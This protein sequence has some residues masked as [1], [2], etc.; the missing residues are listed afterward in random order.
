MKT[1]VKKLP[2]CVYEITIE[3]SAAE[4]EKARKAAL[5]SLSKRVQVKGFRKGAP[6]PEAL[7]LKEVGPGAL[8][9]EALDTYLKKNYSKIL[10]SAKV[11]PIAPG[12]VTK[13]TSLDPL[14]VSIEVETLPEV[15]IDTKKMDSITIKKTKVEADP[16]EVDEAVAEIE[17]RFTHFHDAGGHSED[18]FDASKVQID[19]GDRVTIDTQGFEKQGG[20]AIPETKVQAFPLVIGSGQFIPGFEAKLIGHKTGDV[21]EFEITFPA[22]YHSDAFK[23]R[24]VFFITTIFKVEKPHKPEWTP[25]FIE[26]LRGVKTDMAGFKDILGKEILGEKERKAR[27]TDEKALLAEL[28]KISTY[29]IGKNLLEREIQNIFQEQK[30]NLESQG[31]NMK[32]YLEHLKMSEEAYKEEV[33]TPEARRRISAELIL[34]TIR[35]IRKVEATDEEIQIEING[36][37]A[38]YQNAQVIE[39]LKQKLVP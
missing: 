29:E 39:R 18:G 22:D 35:D 31:Y 4:Y 23:G 12:S 26:K 6:V 32:T 19:S 8:A 28:E 11:T 25:E 2:L 17:K 21:V 9:D 7:L 38:Q 1:T 24:T 37:I 15:T 36:I 14:V 30:G 10:D 33:I 5:E 27:E 13:I 3:D 16:K 20:A 34:K